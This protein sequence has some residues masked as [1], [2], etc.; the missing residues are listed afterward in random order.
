MMWE[1]LLAV[2][3]MLLN[4]F[5][6]PTVFDRDAQIPRT[7]SI[8]YALVLGLLITVPYVMLGLLIPALATG[9]G[10]VLWIY[11]ALYRHT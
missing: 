8:P 5:V 2:G 4:V 9:S 1:T 10:A 3:G 7:Q 11:V 6:L